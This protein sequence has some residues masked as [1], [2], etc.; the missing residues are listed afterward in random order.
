MVLLLHFEHSCAHL[1]QGDTKCKEIGNL[2]T[3]SNKLY[4]LAL[5]NV[6]SGVQKVSKAFEKTEA[7]VT[8]LYTDLRSQVLL[9]AG[10]ILKPNCIAQ[11]ARPGML[12]ADEARML[13]D[14]LSKKDNFLPVDRISLGDSFH[15]AAVEANLAAPDLSRIQFNCGQYIHTLCNLLLD[16]LPSN[17]DGVE[18]LKFL[19]PRMALA[20]SA[21]PTFRQLP[22]EMA[23]GCS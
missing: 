8:K 14:A 2:Y 20:H 23:G 21:R 6:L 5:R 16:K 10:R 3:S 18:K 19:K 22:L 13:K 12:R 7:D 11:V 4:L 17:L 1:F 9:L 15:K